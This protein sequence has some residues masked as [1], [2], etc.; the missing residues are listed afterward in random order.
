MFAFY[1][2][3]KNKMVGF[4]IDKLCNSGQDQEK[5]LKEY[6]RY[7]CLKWLCDDF[8]SQK[9]TSPFIIRAVHFKHT[10]EPF[11]QYF[12]KMNEVFNDIC[13]LKANVND[14]QVK[15]TLL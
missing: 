5:I 2:T 4:N 13:E 1:E 11:F 9:L 3:L 15:S 7:L 8:H 10:K 14:L 6:R 12:T